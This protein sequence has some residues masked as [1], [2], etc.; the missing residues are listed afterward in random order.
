MYVCIYMY[1]YIYIY[2]CMYI[3]VYIYMYVCIYTHVCV[4]VF[5]M[6]ILNQILLYLGNHENCVNNMG[7]SSLNTVDFSQ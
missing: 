6:P 7:D 3:Y 1:I 2:V 5:H 4:W